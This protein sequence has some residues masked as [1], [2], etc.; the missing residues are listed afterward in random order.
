MLGDVALARV[1]L[2]VSAT[3]SYAEIQSAY[4][5]LV[6]RWHPDRAGLDPKAQAER[7]RKTQELTWAMGILRRAAYRGAS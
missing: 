3:A 2:G 1:I 7:T 4:R 5:L 6:S